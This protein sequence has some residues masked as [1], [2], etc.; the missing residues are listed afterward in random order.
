MTGQSV[1]SL[2]NRI[3]DAT[4]RKILGYLTAK[5][6]SPTDIG[7]IFQETYLA[8]HRALQ[9]HG[10]D[11]VKNPD[12]FVMKLARHQLSRYYSLSDRLKACIP[13]QS[14]GDEPDGPGFEAAAEDLPVEDQIVNRDLL[15]R[16]N[17]HLK[18][19]PADVQKIFTLFYA[20]EYT[21]PEIARMLPMKESSVRNKLYRTLHE[22]RS[23]YGKD[24]SNA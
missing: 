12:A 14:G 6:S 20:M 10:T 9:R 1:D 7:D 5:C 19:K 11:Y 17:E 15:E 16:I 8:L 22:L 3:Y 4:R 23:L 13:L 24:D 21:I 2:F 18:Q